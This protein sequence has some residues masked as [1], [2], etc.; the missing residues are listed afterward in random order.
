MSASDISSSDW[1]CFTVDFLAGD[2][3]ASA[4]LAGG[5]LAA[6]GFFLLSA[7]ALP[8]ALAGWFLEEASAWEQPNASHNHA[9][10][11]HC[12]KWL[13]R[14]VSDNTTAYTL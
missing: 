1:I 5:F 4:F 2:F 11:S 6:D 3:L 8:L 7:A 14:K 10:Q 13:N 9:W 12:V